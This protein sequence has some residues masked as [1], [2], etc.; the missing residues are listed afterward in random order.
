MEVS[1]K[2]EDLKKLGLQKGNL[3]K[4]REPYD[5]RMSWPIIFGGGQYLLVKGMEKANVDYYQP[6]CKP[7]YYAPYYTWEDNYYQGVPIYGD[8]AEAVES[9]AKGQTLEL[10]GGVPVKLHELVEKKFSTSITDGAEKVKVNIYKTS[11]TTVEDNLGKIAPSIKEAALKWVRSLNM[12]AEDIKFIEETFSRPVELF[13]LLQPIL[14]GLDSLLCTSPVNLGALTSV[15]LQDIE[16]DTY[17]VYDKKTVYLL[18][19]QKLNYGHLSLETE[20][21]SLRDAFDKLLTGAVGIEEEDLKVRDYQ[22]IRNKCVGLSNAL[23]EWREASTYMDLPFYI[24]GASITVQCQEK[25]LA[26]L[27]NNLGITESQFHRYYVNCLDEM[28]NSLNLPLLSMKEWFT[29]VHSGDRTLLPSPPVDHHITT[30][31]NSV[32]ID[33]GVIVLYDGVLRAISDL[34][35]SLAISKEAK[36]IYEICRKTVKEFIIPSTFT[37][38]EARNVYVETMR[39]LKEIFDEIKVTGLMPE[40]KSLDLFERDFGHT[41]NRET[42]VTIFLQNDNTKPINEGMV[43]CSEMHWPYKNHAPGF[44]DSWVVGPKRAINFTS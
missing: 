12:E 18:T 29:L 44:E 34:A 42:A 3:L 36:A 1:M 7:V 15:K 20:Q 10:D 37:G 30:K 35:R 40:G 8:I 21:V 41:M 33:S 19:P 39:Q 43:G 24:L 26:Y 31:S 23:R 4:P 38:K 2:K 9:L 11:P 17:A 14:S 16:E 27:K 5:A 32:K 13:A 25:A 22:L 6:R 28:A